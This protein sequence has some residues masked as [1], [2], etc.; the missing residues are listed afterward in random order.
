MQLLFSTSTNTLKCPNVLLSENSD[1]FNFYTCPVVKKTMKMRIVSSPQFYIFLVCF[2]Q[3][4]PSTKQFLSE[5][6]MAAR[7]HNLR[8]SS[9]HNY[10][11]NIIQRFM[12]SFNQASKSSQNQI[13][14]DDD[15]ELENAD[16]MQSR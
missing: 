8:I 12:D 2:R 14:D 15:D 6:R 16:E 9:D 3:D 7:M 11:V 5:E 13:N 1:K 10:P 4:G